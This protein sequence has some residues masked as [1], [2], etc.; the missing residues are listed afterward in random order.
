MV[1]FR[2]PPLARAVGVGA[3][4]T[5]PEMLLYVP[6]IPAAVATVTL[7]APRLAGS[8][9]CRVTPAAALGPLLPKLVVKTNCWPALTGS[10]E[11]V[12]LVVTSAIGVT[13][14]VTVAVLAP[15]SL[16]WSAPVVTVEVAVTLPKEAGTLA[17]VMVALALPP[18]ASVLGVDVNV[19]TPFVLS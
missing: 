13:F 6:V 5:K 19:T 12:M 11:A 17:M 14:T 1:A 16:P 15:V 7:V 9:T 18:L 4:V 10:A 8:C 3:K 2:L